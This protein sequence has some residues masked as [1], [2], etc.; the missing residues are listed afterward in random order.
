MSKKILRRTLFAI[1]ALLLA[2]LAI[3]AS[4]AHLCVDELLAARPAPTSAA[5]SQRQQDILLKIEDPTFF[6]HAG[7]SLADGQGVTTITSAIARDVFLE[8]GELGGMKG[9]FQKLYR[10]VFACCKKV[11][12]GRDVMALVLD[13]H[14]AK[15]RQLDLYVAGV[16]MGTADGIQVK[17]L[18]IASRI[19]FKQPLEELD[20]QRFIGLVAMIKAPN[21]F[22]PL[23]TPG[24]YQVR[25]LLAAR[26]ISGACQPQGW[27]DTTYDRCE[28]ATD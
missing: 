26:M 28:R 6:N 7:L 3:A 18:D 5:L 21:Q 8:G 20:E 22:H 27:F 24:S 14:L 23:R 10:G 2:Y 17:G 1:P 25:Q 4:W 12:F 16:Y 19:Y 11:D 13:R 15:Q 9:A